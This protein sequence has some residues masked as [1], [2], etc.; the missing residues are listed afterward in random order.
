MPFN[1]AVSGLNAASADLN[2]I[3]NNVANAS[4]TGFKASRAEFADVYATSVFGT[5]AVAT[6]GGVRVADVAQH[7]TQGTVTFTNNNLDMAI[8]GEGFFRLNDAGTIVYSRAGAFHADRDG[9][10]INSGEQRLTGYLADGNGTITGQ[11]GDLRI[12]TSN[13]SPAPTTQVDGALNL[14]ANEVPPSVAWPAAPFAFGDPPP[15]LATYNSSTSLTVY[16]S[17]G[18]AHGMSMYFVKTG[19]NSWDVHVLIDGVT[20]GATPAGTL[21][22]LDDG[23]IDPASAIL[24]ITGWNPLDAN[25]NPSGAAAQDFDIS[26]LSSTQ[27]GSAF[28]V[29]ALTQDGFTTGRLAGVDVDA[30]GVVF[31][32]YTNGQLKALG[33]LVLANFANPQGLQPLGDTNWGE[34]FSSGQALLGAPATASLGVVQ[35]GAL[36]ESNVELTQE[37]VKMILAQRNYQA[38]AQTIRTADAITQTIINL[39]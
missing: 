13:I 18:N 20:A 23:S 26:L 32:R 29:N 3:G 24:N 6:G 33:Q 1:I 10:I 15:D 17:L 30:T 2:V 14:D 34:T 19:A 31:G 21:Q 35:S 36:E 39:R 22:F 28:G 5:A 12:D 8:N 27:Y 7:F 37:L 16:D 11:L 4:T 38:N 25:G 9:Y